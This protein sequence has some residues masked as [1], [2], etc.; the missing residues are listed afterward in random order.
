MLQKAEEAIF[1]YKRTLERSPGDD[2]AYKA[3]AYLYDAIKEEELLREW[4]LQR[5]GNGSLP[6]D[7]RAEAFVVLASK[8]W[9]CSFKIT[10]L[11]TTKVTTVRGNKVLVSYQMPKE[12]VEF[13]RANEC[14]NRGLEMAN[15]AI[16]L[17][18]ENESAWSYKTNLLLELAKLAEMEGD[19]H[20]QREL[21]R[22][23]EE[24]LRETTKLSKRSR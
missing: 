21:R 14:A 13:E 24:A 19:V 4:L 9:D 11:P 20:Q 6:N 1:A 22:Q 15:I 17:M 5:A 8:D 12:R 23:Y 16:T 18:P 7:K 2:E 10:E 3:V